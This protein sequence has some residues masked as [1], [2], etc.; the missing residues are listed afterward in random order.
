MP[1]RRFLLEVE[2]VEKIAYG[3]AV[4]WGVSAE[5]G[6]ISRVWQVVAAA[7]R[8]GRHLPVVLDELQDRDMVGVVVGN[9]TGLCPRRNHDQRNARAVAEEVER[10]RLI[11]LQEPQQFQHELMI[12]MWATPWHRRQEDDE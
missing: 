5:C 6:V 9:V 7:A 10:R 12:G 3:R 2:Q 1:R 8:D 4:G 11:L